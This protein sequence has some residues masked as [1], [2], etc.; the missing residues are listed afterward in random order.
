[1]A[2]SIPNPL[3]IVCTKCV[4]IVRIH[5]QDSDALADSIAVAAECCQRRFGFVAGDALHAAIHQ[6]R[7]LTTN[8]IRCVEDLDEYAIEIETR[9]DRHLARAAAVRWA[10]GSGA[11]THPG[12]EPATGGGPAVVWRRPHDFPPENGDKGR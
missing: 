5:Y 3:R 11:G 8:D 10:G 7:D 4:R 1:M 9:A 12:V 2:S 6:G